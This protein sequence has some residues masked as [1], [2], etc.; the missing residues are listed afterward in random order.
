MSLFRFSDT[1]KA[2]QR[3]KQGKER[4]DEQKVVNYCTLIAYARPFAPPV[5]WAVLAAA[6]S[7][8]PYSPRIT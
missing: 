3:E 5:K 8:R 1:E 4:S 2:G 7:P 6:H